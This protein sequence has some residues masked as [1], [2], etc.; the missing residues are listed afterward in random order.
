MFVFEDI[1]TLDDRSIQLVL[2]DVDVKELAVALKGVRGDVRDKILNNM[3]ERVSR[4]TRAW[5]PPAAWL[6]SLA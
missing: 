5:R 4:S 2:R 3:S 6:D 1:T